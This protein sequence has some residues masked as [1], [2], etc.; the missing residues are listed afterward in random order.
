MFILVP[1]RCRISVVMF[2]LAF[3]ALV[4][5]AQ[6]A[7]A[8]HLD[9][10]M[11]ELVKSVDLNF[12]MRAAEAS[13]A[14]VKLGQLAAEK[15]ERGQLKAFGQQMVKDHSTAESEVEAIAGKER[16]TLPAV[17]NGKDEAEFR[18]LEKLSGKC[19][20]PG[21]Y[22]GHGQRTHGRCEGLRKRN[23]VRQK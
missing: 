18:K 11:K 3:G 7:S 14:Q 22:E 15:S 17:M 21:L 12:A 6:K 13:M 4:V 23:E 1:V 20:R 5:A 2:A 9:Q 8:P 10:G 16:M 19:V